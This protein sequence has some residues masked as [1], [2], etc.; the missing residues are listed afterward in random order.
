MSTPSATVTVDVDG[1]EQEW[2]VY[3]L[4][5]IDERTAKTAFD[6]GNRRLGADANVSFWRVANQAQPNPQ[7]RYL[8]AVGPTEDVRAALKHFPG[9]ANWEITD[10]NIIELIVQRR[11]HLIQRSAGRPTSITSHYS[12]IGGAKLTP[13]GG[14]EPASPPAPDR[15]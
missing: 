9:A 8:I 4:A 15:S 5:F 11:L 2:E 1:E 14:V 7:A 3:G 6:R 12:S 10:R 13:D